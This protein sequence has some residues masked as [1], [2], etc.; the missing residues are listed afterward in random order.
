[1]YEASL[2]AADLPRGFFRLTVP[3]GGGKTR[4]SL[5][6][7]LRHAM[8]HGLARIIYAIPY[9]SIIEQTCDVFREIFMDDQAVLEHH[10]AARVMEDEINPSA[11]R[12][13]LGCDR[14]TGTSESGLASVESGAEQTHLRSSISHERPVHAHSIPITE[15]CR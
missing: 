3:T 6:F 2:H 1:M 8:R 14:R 5:A 9:T 4:S 12:R 10:S 7:A 15:A 11:R 13:I